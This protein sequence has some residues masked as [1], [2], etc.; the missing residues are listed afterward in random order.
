MT[1]LLDFC[2][3]VNAIQHSNGFR[4]PC[5]PAARGRRTGAGF[6]ALAHYGQALILPVMNTLLTIIIV[7]LL[8]AI[9]GVLATGIVGMFRGGD[10][11]RANRLMRYRV[12]LQFGLL[13]LMA[14]F[15]LVFHR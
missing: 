1:Y 3:I 13:M 9:L 14:L 7:G 2:R 4:V 15:M 12:M 5:T 8:L 11:R 6:E 10:A